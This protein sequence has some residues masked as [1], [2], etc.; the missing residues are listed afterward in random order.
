MLIGLLSNLSV[1]LV[2]AQGGRERK[3]GPSCEGFGAL[4]RRR[5]YEGEERNVSGGRGEGRD[6]G[7]GTT[8][9]TLAHTLHKHVP[10]YIEHR[11]PRFYSEGNG[12]GGKASF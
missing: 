1:H 5:A 11:H 9:Q 7:L 4:A 10:I 3:L 2:S 12:L 8:T 6:K